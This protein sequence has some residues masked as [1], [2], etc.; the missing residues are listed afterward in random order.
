MP[1]SRPF[2]WTDRNGNIYHYFENPMWM[3]SVFILMQELC[4]RLAFFGLHPNLQFFL[5]DFLQYDDVQADS[6][7]SIFNVLLYVSPLLGGILADTL[8]GVYYAILGFS[9]IYML[10]LV[11]LTL[12]SIP[13][14]SEPWMIH[15]SLMVLIAVGAGGIK[16]CVNVMGAQQMHPSEHKKLITRFF[17]Y[18]YATICLGAIIGGTVT[19]ILLQQVGWTA[20]FAFPLAF[21]V[22]ATGVFVIGDLMNRYVKVKPQGSAVLQVIKVA[23]FS[24]ARCSLEKN[25]ESNGGR[26]KDAYIEDTRIFFYLLPLFA[27]IVPFNMAHNNMSTTFLTQ[28]SKMDRRTFGWTIPPAMIHNVNPVA[29]IVISMLVDRLLYPWLR[30]RGLMP[31]VLVRFCIGS[32]LGV[33]SL[34]CA[35]IVEYVIMNRPLF[36]ISIWWQL[37]QFLFIAAGETILIPTTYEV[38]F[39]H[40]PSGLKTVASAVNLCFFAIDSSLS[41]VLFRAASPWLPNFDPKNPEESVIGAHYDFY[42]Y[43]LIGLCLCDAVCCLFMMP[44]YRKVHRASMARQEVETGKEDP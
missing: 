2:S 42:Y 10:G 29:I 3:A 21:F 18:F 40:S 7:I 37:P 24:L 15:L 35:L 26:F 19:P 8:T 28:A 12:A 30:K 4:E 11:L 14:I 32:L 27:L 34:I 9:V 1:Y 44:Y 23:V 20:S 43:V 25:K 13:S 33:L 41:A 38:A 31:P 39:T 16:S 5:K 6:Y 22:V 36:T 17:T